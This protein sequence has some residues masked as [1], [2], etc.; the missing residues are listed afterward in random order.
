MEENFIL[1]GIQRGRLGAKV[2]P[3]EARFG[4][5]LDWEKPWLAPGGRGQ[6]ARE[7]GKKTIVGV[8]RPGEARFGLEV[9][10]GKAMVAP[11]VQS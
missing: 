7:K 9:R 1:I 11:G 2:R 10:W 5:E 6:D 8:A 3:G 4:L